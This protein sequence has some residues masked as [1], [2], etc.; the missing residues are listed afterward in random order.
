MSKTRKQSLKRGQTVRLNRVA[1]YCSGS[2][3]SLDH[4]PF[5]FQVRPPVTYTPVAEEPLR[6][7]RCGPDNESHLVD[8]S[9]GTEMDARRSAYFGRSEF[10]L[11][12]LICDLRV[13]CSTTCLQSLR[14]PFPPPQGIP[15]LILSR[16]KRR[17][18]W[19]HQVPVPL[20]LPPQ[21]DSSRILLEIFWMSPNQHFDQ[22]CTIKCCLTTCLDGPSFHP[23]YTRA[24][25]SSFSTTRD[26]RS[27]R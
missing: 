10:S 26:Q 13:D 2:S 11:E 16:G 5:L 23:R 1:A 17:G 18:T 6:C 8:L 15:M 14:R 19:C 22:P 9:L 21:G 27:H 4:S 20:E 12:A 24:V 25:F 7:L 3:P